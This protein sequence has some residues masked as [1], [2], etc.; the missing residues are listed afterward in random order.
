VSIWYPPA[1]PPDQLK[2]AIDRA[3]DRVAA[4]VPV[5]RAIVDGRR[6]ELSLSHLKNLAARNRDRLERLVQRAEALDARGAAAEV[7]SNKV[8]DEHEAVFRGIE[9][10]LGEVDKFNSEMKAQLGNS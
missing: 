9:E 8:F 3:T 2:D 7:T 10:Q 1:K 5:A 6:A 4:A